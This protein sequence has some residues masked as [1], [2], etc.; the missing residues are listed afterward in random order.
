MILDLVEEEYYMRKRIGT[1]KS[2]IMFNLT[3]YPEVKVLMKIRRNITLSSVEQF[4]NSNTRVQ[5]QINWE[6]CR[7]IG[8]LA[9]PLYN[10]LTNYNFHDTLNALA[11]S[12]FTL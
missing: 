1:K 11:K 8:R 4:I 10:K 7:F 6:F 3:G 12:R 5:D 2:A 9:V